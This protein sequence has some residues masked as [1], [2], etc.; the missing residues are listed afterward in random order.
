TV[1]GFISALGENDYLLASNY[2]N[3]SKSDN[4]TTVVR[5]F[6]QALDA[7]GRFQPD[8][9]ISNSPEG[10]LTDQLPPS[11]ENVGVINIGE[12]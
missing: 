7:G 1:Q 2:L 10:N 4:P 9:Q 5:Q 12:R 6:K 3:L 11:Q 8:L